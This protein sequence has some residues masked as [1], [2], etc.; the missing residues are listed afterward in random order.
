MVPASPESTKHRS[1]VRGGVDK[2]IEV[3][4]TKIDTTYFDGFGEVEVYYKITEKGEFVVKYIDQVGAFKDIEF[5]KNVA[6]VL[7]DLPKW[8]P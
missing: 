4:N 1:I 5:I 2:F 6:L 8:T 3:I 7:S